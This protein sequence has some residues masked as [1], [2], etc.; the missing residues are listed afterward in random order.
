MSGFKFGSK[1]RAELRG[2]HHDLVAVVTRALA[3]SPV[4]F[5]VHDG[6]RTLE[7]Q[8][9]YVKRGVS[10]TMKSRHLPDANG[11]GRAVDLVPWINGKLRWEWPPIYQIAEAMRAAALEMGVPIVWGGIWA[12]LDTTTEKTSKLVSDYVEM[13][14]R[15]GLTAFTDGVHFEL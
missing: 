11:I 2:V 3:L 10:R 6:I 5:A 8:R 4:D 14:R 15:K 1:S 7:E 13:R 12:R 9:E